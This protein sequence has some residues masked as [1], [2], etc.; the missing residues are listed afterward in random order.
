MNVRERYR[1][2]LSFQPVDRLPMMEW[3]TWWDKTVEAWKAQGLRIQSEPGLRDG[4]ALQRQL[5]LDLHMQY[6]IQFTTQGT[7]KPAYHG[8][9]LIESMAD[10]ER[11]LPTLY[12][13]GALDMARVRSM[14]AFQQRGEAV[15]W[16]TLEGFFWGPRRLMGIEPHLFGF[17][18]EPELM[19]RIN[20]DLCDYNLYLLEQ[21]LP[22]HTPDF[23]TFAEDLGYNL[24]PMISMAQFDEFLLPYYER[25]V[26]VLKAHGIRVFVDSD[27]DITQTL[28]WFARAGVEG[29]LPLERQAGV[30][31]N[32]SRR[33]FPQYLFIGHY[34]KMVMPHGEA[35]MRAEFERLLPVMRQGGFIPSV[36]H[37]TPPGVTFE[38]Y[39]IYLR[40][41]REYTCKAAIKNPHD[42]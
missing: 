25:I 38:Q 33:D 35:A 22:H 19:H 26:P 7:P 41:L 21:L 27:G 39:Q 2:V 14:E 36:D 24:G 18:D 15:T 13:R 11:I 16:I 32:A 3:A 23:M 10:Y 40:L 34:D 28:P 30:D 4:E 37:Q 12:P 20:S 42:F 8:A 17:Y 29:I 5:G 1:R 9:P 6:W 31:L